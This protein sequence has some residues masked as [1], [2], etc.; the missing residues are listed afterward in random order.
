[1]HHHSTLQME[2]KTYKYNLEIIIKHK[3]ITHIL[4]SFH[5]VPQT[6]GTDLQILIYISISTKV[7]IIAATRNFAPLIYETTS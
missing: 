4:T 1:M 6:L 3:Y 7:F 5:Q 2:A